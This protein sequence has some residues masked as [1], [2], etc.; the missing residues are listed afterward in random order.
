MEKHAIDELSRTLASGASRR[1]LLRLL[2]GGVAVGAVAATGLGAVEAKGKQRGK[3]GQRVSAAN[4]LANIPITGTVDGTA[5]PGTSTFTVTRFAVQNHQL[6]ALGTLAGTGT[7]VDGQQIALPVGFGPSGASATSRRAAAAATCQILHLTLGPLDLT[8]LGLHVHLDQVVLDIT[9][10]SGSGNLLGNLLCAVAHL[11][12]SN[13]SLTALANL[14][15]QI[16]GIL[17]GL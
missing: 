1:Q 13:G 16:L 3:H 4:P 12:D 9:A 15:N 10:Q 11:L 17:Q 2:G 8:L 14:L 5:L 6:V 7:A